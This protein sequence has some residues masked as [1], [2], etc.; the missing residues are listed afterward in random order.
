[1]ENSNVLI[2]TSAWIEFFREHSKTAE[3]VTSLIETGRASL[4]GL[5]YYELL[6]GTKDDEEALRLP[7][8]L[9]ALKYFEMTPDAWI[10]SGHVGARLRRKGITLPMSDILVGM[11]A[12]EHG[13]QV[14]TLDKHFKSIPGL[15]LY[16]E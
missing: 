1:L 6:Q 16:K 2:D 9:S 3:T 5:I 14:P 8:A 12:M 4:C 10:Q 7:N 11:V 13:L 15:I